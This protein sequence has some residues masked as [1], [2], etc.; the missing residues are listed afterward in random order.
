MEIVVEVKNAGKKKLPWSIFS[1][2][3]SL[4]ASTMLIYPKTSNEGIEVV[5]VCAHSD[6]DERV[7]RNEDPLFHLR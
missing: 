7:K 3:T 2:Y 5:D 4:D 1:L 6:L